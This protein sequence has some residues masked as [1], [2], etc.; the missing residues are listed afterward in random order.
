MIELDGLHVVYPERCIRAL[1]GVDLHVE[2]GERVALVGPSGA[3]KSSLLRALLGA[4]PKTAGTARVGG[5]DPWGPGHEVRELRRAT[6]MIRQGDDL[7]GVS[8]GRLNAVS[9]TAA[10]WSVRDWWAVA[11]RRVP[12][13][14]DRRLDELARRHGVAGLLDAPIEQLSGGQRQRLA[15]CRA[16]LPGPSLLLADEPTANLDPP[17]AAAVVDALLAVDG[18]TVLVATHDLAVARRFARTVAVRDGRTVHDGPALDRATEHL[19]Y[20]PSA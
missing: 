8:T 19:V 2:A 15:L 17:A 1:D 18:V 10:S 12:A 11:R 3:G 7:V 14:Y 5:R 6:G 9:G 16:L 13:R 4:V 20:G